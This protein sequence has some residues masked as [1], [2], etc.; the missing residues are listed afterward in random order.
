MLSD[1]RYLLMIKLLFIIFDV[2]LKSFE[3]QIWLMSF[4]DNQDFTDVRDLYYHFCLQF[5]VFN[6]IEC[7]NIEE[8]KG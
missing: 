6:K 3:F 2:L 8:I 4:G 1:E 7:F 5:M